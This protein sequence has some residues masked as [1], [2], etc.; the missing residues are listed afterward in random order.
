MKVVL[1]YRELS[2]RNRVRRGGVGHQILAVG[3][4]NRGVH[5]G[6]PLAELE[7]PAGAG[8]GPGRG[9]SQEVD[10]EVGGDG[11]RHR[12]DMGKHRAPG[13][14]IGEREERGAGNSAA[15]G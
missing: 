11:K 1:R 12:P 6:Q 7:E 13:A 9:L 4:E 14:D 10:V 8:E 3:I 2:R 5:D 15:R